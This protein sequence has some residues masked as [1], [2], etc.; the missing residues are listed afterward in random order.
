MT[1]KFELDK[2]TAL[3]FEGRSLYSH[4]R[5]STPSQETYRKTLIVKGNTHG[6]TSRTSRSNLK[7]SN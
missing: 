5:R 6:Q 2:S 1:K 3:E 7:N 4:R